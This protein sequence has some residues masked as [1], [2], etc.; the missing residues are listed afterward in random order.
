MKVLKRNG[1]FEDVSFDKV[2]RRIK[3]VTKQCGGLNIDVDD[4]AQLICSHIFD[5]V[6]TSDLDELTGRITYAKVTEHPDYGKLASRIIISNHH[7][8]TLNT[9]SEKVKLLYHNTRCLSS[10][11]YELVKKHSTFLDNAIKYERDFLFDYFAFKTL[12][13]SYLLKIKNKIIER[14][15]DLLMR[16]SLALHEDNLDLVLNTY[17]LMSQKYFI[18]ATPTLYHAGSEKGQFLSCFLLGTNDSIK[19]IYKTISDCAVISKWAGGIG[20]HVSNIR[21][22]DSLIKGTNGRSDGIVPMLKVYNYTA[23]YANQAGRRAGSFAIY[24]EPHHAD[25]LDFLNMKKTHGD[26]DKRAL[27]LFYGIMLSDLFMDRVEKNEMWSLFSPDE[28]PGLEDSYGEQYNNLYLKY[29]NEKRFRRQLPARE[30][31][32]A[33]LNAQIETG[34]PYLLCKDAI[35]R[36][37]NQKNIG[38][39]KSSNLC[40]EIVQ[41]SDD[42]E[43][44]CCTLAS[45]SLASFVENGKYNFEKL[46]EVTKTLVDN[47]NKIIDKNFYPVP[48]TKLSNFRHRPLGI[49]VQGLQNAFFKLKL[50]FDSDEARELNAKIFETIHFAALTKSNE[51]AKQDGKY[52]TFD[53]SPMSNGKFQFDLWDEELEKLNEQRNFSKT[54]LCGDYD[55]E[56]L[57]KNIIKYGLRNSL[58]TTCMPTASTSN[59]LGNFESMEPITS[60]IFTR[61]T[62]SGTFVILNDYLINDLIDLNLWSNDMKEEIIINRGSIQNINIIPQNIK[63]LY[64]TVWDLSQKV[65]IQLSADRAKFIDQTQSL[66]LYLTDPTISKLSSMH[67]YSY[68]LGL[69]TLCYYLRAKN[70]VNPQQFSIDANKLETKKEF[71]NEIIHQR[72]EDEK[73][74]QKVI[75]QQKGKDESD[76]QRVQ[77]LCS[78]KNG[79]N[80]ES[81]SG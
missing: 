53:G 19:G 42:K 40:S 54:K 9:F 68:K 57:R 46:Q 66:N 51:L 64:K 80:C 30:V 22:N 18:H 34:T 71:Q 11:F 60:N 12:E 70:P 39:I 14:P 47:L 72:E 75:L 73:L 2:L 5:G 23:R 58:L 41:Y 43:Y 29:E 27:D 67:F 62:L 37:S 36:K 35:N 38:T 21:A 16:V 61:G 1:Q 6:K 56:N 26:M 17:E 25:I 77:M 15:Q 63:N 49:G 20:V 76:A 33:I 69:K 7:K 8:E 31:W 10:K 45:I 59:I 32:F 50:P 55:W 79:P 81:C 28:S 24:L 74:N 4:I 3:M 78:L 52:E 48:E 13:R 65:T 44:S